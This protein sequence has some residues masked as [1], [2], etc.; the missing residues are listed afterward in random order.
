MSPEFG[1]VLRGVVGAYEKSLGVEG[2][3]GGSDADAHI[4][5]AIKRV[6]ANGSSATGAGLGKLMCV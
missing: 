1:V 6:I 4:Q 5:G 2:S 3:V